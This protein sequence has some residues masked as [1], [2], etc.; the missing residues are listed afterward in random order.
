MSIPQYNIDC[1]G[2]SNN[3]TTYTHTQF[4]ACE[5]VKICWSYDPAFSDRKP[6]GYRVYRT[7]TSPVTGVESLCVSIGNSKVLQDYSVY[8]NTLRFFSSGG[9]STA[10]YNNHTPYGIDPVRSSIN[11]YREHSEYISASSGDHYDL[12]TSAF[13]IDIWVGRFKEPWL[14][15]FP[16]ETILSCF[17]S[18][19]NK[20]SWRLF[21]EPSSVTASV[22]YIPWNVRTGNPNDPYHLPQFTPYAN[23]DSTQGNLIL[24]VYENG[25]GTGGKST[26]TI[27]SA[28]SN[29][30]WNCSFTGSFNKY[31]FGHIS[32]TRE[33]NTLRVYVDGGLRST[34]NVPFDLAYDDQQLIIGKHFGASGR[35][36][37]SHFQDPTAVPVDDGAV[38]HYHG[39]V[40]DLRILKNFALPPPAGGRAAN[41]CNQQPWYDMFTEVAVLPPNVTCW[42]DKTA[43]KGVRT[44]YRVAAVNCDVDINCICPNYIAGDKEES[45]NILAFVATTPAELLA[46]LTNP[47]PDE[48]DIFNTWDRADP[49]SGDYYPG[50]TGAVGDSAGWVFDNVKRVFSQPLNTSTPTCIVSPVNQYMNTYTHD[51]VVSSSDSDDDTI[52]VVGA[53]NVVNNQQYALVFTRT[54]GGQR[55]YKGW[56]ARVLWGDLGSG[57]GS[58]DGGGNIF[59]KNLSDW[60]TCG[61]YQIETLSTNLGSRPAGAAC[62][63][64]YSAD[65]DGWSNRQTRIQVIRDRQQITAKTSPMIKGGAPGELRASHTL[66]SATAI[67]INLN[68]TPPPPGMPGGW[69]PLQGLTGYGFFS[70]SQPE[71]TFYDWDVDPKPWRRIFDFSLGSP[72]AVWE[73]GINNRWYRTLDTAWEAVHK[74]RTIVVDYNTGS[75]HLLDCE[76]KYTKL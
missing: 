13:T 65:N 35:L 28:T 62:N 74:T 36:T 60:G 37:P 70:W 75:R 3:S 73:Y 14:Y 67:T 33:V 18:T 17:D 51:V 6:Q 9:E 64:A 40:Y 11:L 71:S 45:Q 63:V 54:A 29:P 23:S 10:T 2:W 44:F 49:S 26:H 15:H 43:P 8:N 24:E 46:Y 66:D 5:S 68:S 55:P 39:R 41:I 12:S 52:G 50:G 61:G 59:P 42:E 58:S 53:Y 30:D 56:G 34:I 57:L 21:F 25:D 69:G 16:C 48:E 20:R 72:G 31:G 27:M 19:S 76:G 4:T 7:T 22:S 47:P 1:S 38:S 32:I